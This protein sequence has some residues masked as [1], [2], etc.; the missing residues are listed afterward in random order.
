[1]R[2]DMYIYI[3]ENPDNYKKTPY[4]RPY[5]TLQDHITVT[6]VVSIYCK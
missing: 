3:Y 5:N 1:M 2:N 6:K 4:K